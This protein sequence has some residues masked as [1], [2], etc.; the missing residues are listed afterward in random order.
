MDANERLQAMIVYVSS[1]TVHLPGHNLLL[2][3]ADCQVRHRPECTISTSD[4][5]PTSDSSNLV[6]PYATVSAAVPKCV[7]IH[8]MKS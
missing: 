8:N 4:R 2:E 3:L 6:L 1:S 5:C 7:C